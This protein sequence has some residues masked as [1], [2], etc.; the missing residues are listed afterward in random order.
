[1][2]Q[3][4]LSLI[5]LFMDKDMFW[6]FQSLCSCTSRWYDMNPCLIS[7]YHRSCRI[8]WYFIKWAALWAI[9]I[10]LSFMLLGNFKV[11]PMASLKFHPRF[12]QSISHVHGIE[13]LIFFWFHIPISLV[14]ALISYF[15]SKSCKWSKLGLIGFP[16]IFEQSNSIFSKFMILRKNVS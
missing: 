1:M 8:L 3:V 7:I 9:W 10:P 11:A 12:V 15:Q 14:L 2:Q 4:I 5:F 6:S 13:I 16:M